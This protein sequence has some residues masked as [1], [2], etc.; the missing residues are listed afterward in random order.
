MIGVLEDPIMVS[1]S[2]ECPNSIEPALVKLCL[3]SFLVQ[4]K[5]FWQFVHTWVSGVDWG[6]CEC[7]ADWVNP[8][9]ALLEHFVGT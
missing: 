5:M 2:L 4:D 3:V 9:Q 6:K 1:L 8:N 7:L